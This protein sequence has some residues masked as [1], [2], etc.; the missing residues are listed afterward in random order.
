LNTKR[1]YLIAIAITALFTFS[2]T[3]VMY[4]FLGFTKTSITFSKNKVS[5]E[6]VQK[7]EDIKS[8]IK[9][10]FYKKVNEDKLLEG[11]IGGMVS[12]LDQYSV[13]FTK[14]QMEEFNKIHSETTETYVGIGVNVNMD[15]NNIL[16]INSFIEGSPAKDAGMK[17]GD[18]IYYVDGEDVRKIK[19]ENI[20][21]S[22]IKGK[23]NTY[24]DITAYRPSEDKEVK[25]KIKRKKITYTYNL[26]GEVL[27]GGLG[28]IH[29]EL[30]D[31]NISNKF[32]KELEKLIN[33]GIKGL[34]IDLR[35]N[36][37]GDFNGCVNIADRLLPEAVI[38]SS[39]GRTGPEYVKKSDEKEFDMPIVIL[40]N[41][42]S[43]SASEIL[44]AALK[45]NKKGILIG[46]KTYGKGLI[47][48]L[49]MFKDGSG[50]KYTRAEYFTPSGKSINEKGIKPDIEVKNDDKYYMMPVNM[51]EGNNDKQLNKAIEVL[52]EKI[53]KE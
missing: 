49:R 50:F 45:D 34:I 3:N 25:F 20:I 46:E 9:K 44:S 24:V 52:K 37:G 48:D 35:Y 51:I 11:A 2:L 22:K 29:I 43:A 40:I 4:V 26:S 28:Y 42:Q 18:K 6:N 36:P 31:D 7:F 8:I 53:S 27:D 38:V 5:K 21:I 32:N 15:E 33:D 13:Y 1:N 16:T 10:N 30:F 23:D 19:D 47:Q 14:K 12:S 17:K 39:K 41:G